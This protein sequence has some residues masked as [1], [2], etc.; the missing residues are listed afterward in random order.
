MLLVDSADWWFDT[1]MEGPGE[2][3]ALLLHRDKHAEV[4][5]VDETLGWFDSEG[6]ATEWLE[7]NGYVA[8]KRALRERLVSDVPPDLSKSKRSLK[9]ARAAASPDARVRVA[10]SAPDGTPDDTASEATDPIDSHASPGDAEPARA[11][12]VHDPHDP[13]A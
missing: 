2:W 1:E 13:R 10:A 4:L 6:E 3:V 12:A 7:D 5:C 11:L 8:P 9:R